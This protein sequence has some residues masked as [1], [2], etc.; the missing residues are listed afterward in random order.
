M[1]KGLPIT[2]EEVVQQKKVQIP[3]EVFNAF[4]D[5]IAKH[6][7]GIS[8]RFTQNA[9]VVAILAYL[10]EKNAGDIFSNHWLDVEDIYREAGW[11]VV[12]DRPGYCDSYEA[13]FEFSKKRS[14]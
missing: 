3:P 5:M 4:N 14:H 11:R 13:T 7:N 6:W 1:K 8:A 12:F 2:P 9:V 10:P